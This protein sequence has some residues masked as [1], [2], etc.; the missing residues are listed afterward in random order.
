MKTEGAYL[1]EQKN[2][3]EF[4]NLVDPPMCNPIRQTIDHT[5]WRPAIIRQL[6]CELTSPMTSPWS[7]A[8]GTHQLLCCSC[9]SCNWFLHLKVS[10]FVRIQLL[11][12]TKFRKKIKTTI[13]GRIVQFEFETTQI[14]W[15]MPE[16]NALKFLSKVWQ[17]W[18]GMQPRVCSWCELMFNGPRRYLG[19]EHSLLLARLQHSN[20]RIR[21]ELFK[22]MLTSEQC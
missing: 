3:S 6:G 7:P 21:V 22:A 11:R 8:D 19:E 4:V 14:L 9:S 17:I 16:R 5:R 2:P 1:S 10:A 18:N 15:W 13:Q 20:S 12:T